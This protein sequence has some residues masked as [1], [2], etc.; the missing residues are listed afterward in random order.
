MQKVCVSVVL[1]LKNISAKSLEIWM[2]VREDDGPLNGLLEFPGGKFEEGETHRD[3]AIREIQEEVGIDISKAPLILYKL[4]DT[5]YKKPV[6]LHAFISNFT[7]IQ[8]KK[9]N[10]KLFDYEH[11]SEYLKGQIPQINHQIIDELLDYFCLQMQENSKDRLERLW[12]F[13]LN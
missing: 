4:F 8:E 2:Q 6:L 13:T 3:A 10:W 11:K 5:N 9:G 7:D 1:F 12:A